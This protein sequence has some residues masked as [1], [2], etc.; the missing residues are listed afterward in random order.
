MGLAPTQTAINGYGR[1]CDCGIGG[2]A[3]VTGLGRYVAPAPRVVSTIP[4]YESSEMQCSPGSST[5][6]ADAR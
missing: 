5:T 2:D 3:G 4:R 6:M 1:D